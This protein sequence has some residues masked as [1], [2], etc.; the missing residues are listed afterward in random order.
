MIK[1]AHFARAL[2]ARHNG[3]YAGA[4]LNEIAHVGNTIIYD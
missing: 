2:S 1:P 4:G 3:W